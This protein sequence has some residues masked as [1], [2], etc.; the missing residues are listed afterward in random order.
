MSLTLLVDQRRRRVAIVEWFRE[1]NGG[2][3]LACGPA[4]DIALEIFRESGHERT[5]RHFADYARRRIS[6][7]EA[8]RVFE[9]G[10]ARKVMSGRQAVEIHED[11]PGMMEMCPMAIDKYSLSHLRRIDGKSAVALNS[12]ADVF[13]HTFDEVLGRAEPDEP[14]L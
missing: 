1:T 12:S 2:V 6:E 5:I 13:W 14:A 4:S 7:P 9:P 3:D 8:G 10:Q 11:P